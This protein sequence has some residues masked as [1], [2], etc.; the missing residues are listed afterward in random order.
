[1]WHV[2]DGMGWWM[3]RGGLMM[4]LFWGA[5]VALVVWANKSVVKLEGEKD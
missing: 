1:M 5:V 3:P 2:G 4:I